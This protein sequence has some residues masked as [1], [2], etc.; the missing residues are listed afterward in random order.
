MMTWSLKNDALH[1]LSLVPFRT[2][3][4]TAFVSMTFVRQ[5]QMRIRLDPVGR[6]AWSLIV[7]FQEVS[8]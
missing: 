2:K 3:M 5:G 7:G 6:R 4:M 8:S 1:A